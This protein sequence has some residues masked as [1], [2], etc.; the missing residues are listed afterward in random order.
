MFNQTFFSETIARIHKSIPKM[1]LHSTP[2]ASL[3]EI[4]ETCRRS[5]I[6]LIMIVTPSYPY[7]DYRLLSLGYWP[8]LEQW[9]HR[10]SKYPNV[11]TFAQNTLT[12]EPVIDYMHYWNDPIHFNLSFGRLM[13]RSFLGYKDPE[14]PKNFML[15]LNSKTIDGIVRERKRGIQQWAA[16]HPHF[17][18]I[19]EKAKRDAGLDDP[20]LNRP[21][22]SRG[23]R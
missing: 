8:L 3:D 10:I 11:Y 14:M 16:T 20:S 17:V 22:T 5:H 4:V 23:G 1:Q 21:V 6:H 7:D 9:L 18:Q 19:F 12:T 2:F 13:L 15:P